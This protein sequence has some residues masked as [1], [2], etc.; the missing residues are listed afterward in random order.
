MDIIS[1][2]ELLVNSIFEAKEKFLSDP[3]DFY[4]FEKSVKSVRDSFAAGFLG[5]VLSSVNDCI[6]NSS[7]R[8]GKYHI[9]RTDTRTLISSVS[10][11]ALRLYLL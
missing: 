8:D 9:Q 3:T 7:W 2:L 1:L 10:D 5:K 6:R 4:S 11:I